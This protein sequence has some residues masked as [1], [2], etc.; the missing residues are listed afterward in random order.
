MFK[1]NIR[2]SAH[3]I[4]GFPRTVDSVTPLN[5]ECIMADAVFVNAFSASDSSRDRLS[6]HMKCLNTYF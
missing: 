4:E 3:F 6:R 5:F 2:I 1:Y